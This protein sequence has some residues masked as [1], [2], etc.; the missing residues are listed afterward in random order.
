MDAG[1]ATDERATL[2]TAKSCGPDAPTLASSFRGAIRASEGGKKARSPGRARRKPLKPSRAGMPGDPGATVVTNACAYYT[3]RT[4][5]RVQRAPGIPRSPWGSA[6]P[7]ISGR[8]IHAPLGRNAPRECGYSSNRHRPARPDDPVFQ[9]AGDG[10]ERLPGTGYSAFAEYDGLLWSSASQ[11]HRGASVEASHAAGTPACA[12]L[13][14]L[15]L[16]C[17]NILRSTA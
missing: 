14:S 10:I 1:G 3:S 15:T 17:K 2:R 7:S 16:L 6:T 12:R 4:R 5:P 11:S 9:G 13:L 8:K